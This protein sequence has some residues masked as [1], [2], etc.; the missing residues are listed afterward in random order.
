MRKMFNCVTTKHTILFFL[1]SFV[2]ITSNSL[3]QIDS[4]FVTRDYSAEGNG[5]AMVLDNSG[6][7]FVCGNVN[8]LYTV[9]KY[10]SSGDLLWKQQTMNEGVAYNIYLDENSNVYTAGLYHGTINSVVIKK[11]NSSGSEFWTKTLETNSNLNDYV[12]IISDNN[13]NS[14]V[15]YSIIDSGT[16]TTQ[17]ITKKCDGNGNVLYTLVRNEPGF[18]YS[19]IKTDLQGN[20]FILYMESF[21]ID[22]LDASG[23]IMWTREFNP[24]DS[25]YAS[26]FCID[27]NSNVYIIGTQLNPVTHKDFVTVKYSANGEF[28]WDEYYFNDSAEVDNL[29]EGVCITIGSDGY[30]YSV[31]EAHKGSLGP[32][33]CLRIIKYS[34]NG[35]KIWHTRS[36][37]T[38][39]VNVNNVV[40]DV[41]SNIYVTY[42]QRGLNGGA[43]HPAYIRKF[44]N[45]GNPAWVVKGYTREYMND[46]FVDN[47]F[48][49]I[50]IGNSKISLDGD[51]LTLR[52]Y[53][54]KVSGI[55][56][57]TIPVEYSLS[58]NYPNPF[59]PTTQISFDIK[60]QGFVSLTVYDFLGRGI[61]TLVNDNLQPGSYNASF[62]GSG[63]SSGIY[64]YTLSTEGFTS[65]KKML[66]VK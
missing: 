20:T 23:N 56:N 61:N 33:K 34:S 42:S 44:D 54:E 39:I 8:N 15:N 18:D 40:T 43:I 63:L 38:M 59:N 35:S 60:E 7:I 2:F 21:V 62:D 19:K 45:N 32:Y 52:K 49:I 6:N 10:S 66:L 46:L 5:R 65:T 47:E 22:K 13:G 55:S 11:M 24:A 12:N 31:G 58:Q 9:S 25:N 17:F 3:A 14:I 41:N 26:D 36:F 4:I 37:T 50:T 57:N 30:I 27:G 1:L 53:G 28:Q 16:S 64:F 51:L 48:N 29:D